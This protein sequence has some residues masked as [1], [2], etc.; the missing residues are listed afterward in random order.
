MGMQAYF[1]TGDG[2]T[3]LR[4]SG[5]TEKAHITVNP[6]TSSREEG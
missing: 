2:A 5:T 6:I 3:R 4:T 1:V